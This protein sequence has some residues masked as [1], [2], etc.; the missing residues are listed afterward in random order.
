MDNVLIDYLAVFP[1][2]E[3][4]TIKEYL[5]K[6]SYDQ[7]KKISSIM[8]NEYSTYY[9][10]NHN[11]HCEY[12]RFIWLIENEIN[13]KNS[14]DFNYT[15]T[16]Y[17]ILNNYHGNQ[18]DVNYFVPIEFMLNMLRKNEKIVQTCYQTECSVDSHKKINFTFYPILQVG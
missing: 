16:I 8:N 10:S 14:K 17:S 13:N 5:N 6:C 11:D 3:T 15:E 4:N 7:L 12:F 2:G 9:K 1:Y 18:L